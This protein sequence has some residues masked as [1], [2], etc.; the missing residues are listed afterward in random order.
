MTNARS[1]R[2]GYLF[3]MSDACWRLCTPILMLGLSGCFYDSRWGQEKT[4]QKHEAARQAPQKL[5]AQSHGHDV[6]LAERTLRLRVYATPGYSATVVNWQ[7]QFGDLLEC[8]NSVFI[9]EFGAKFEVVEFLPFRPEANEEKLDGVLTELTAHD[10]A[11]DVDWVVGLATAVPRFAASADDLGLA[12]LLGNHL[13]MRAMSDAQEYEAIQAAFSELSENERLK[14]YQ[15]RKRHKLC[16]VFLHEI[17]HTLGVPHELPERSL[18]N[19]HYHVKEQGFSDEAARVVRASLRVRANQPTVFLDSAFTQTLNSSLSAANTDWEPT[20]RDEVLER[21]A[22]F[23]G[24]RTPA[25]G[26][27]TRAALPPPT[28]APRTAGLNADEQRSYDR[29]RA[30]LSAGHAQAAR[31]I[32]EDLLTKR[33]ELPAVQSLRCEI[34]MA[35]GGAWETISRECAGLSAFGK[36]QE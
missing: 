2:R 18:M 8:A 4:I 20:T 31:Q 14:L 11:A 1:P 13:A 16:S 23:K 29:A 24:G 5:A 28:T 27:A 30:E 3:A 10:R 32:A 33:A 17:A 34:A 6:R 26:T 9:P 19:A 36:L 15:A 25:Q 21:L 22:S 12:P 7:K 35:I